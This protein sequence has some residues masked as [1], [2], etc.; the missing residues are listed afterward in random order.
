MNI[1]Y[2]AKCIENAVSE[3]YTVAHLH[4]VHLFD[5]ALFP[6]GDA[7]LLAGFLCLPRAEYL[8]PVSC[9][10]NDRP[11]ELIVTFLQNYVTA[12]QQ[13]ANFPLSPSKKPK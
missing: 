12:S 10:R 9:P 4:S 6:W 7:V 13:G 5:S 8:P 3:R 11:R 1:Q 2:K